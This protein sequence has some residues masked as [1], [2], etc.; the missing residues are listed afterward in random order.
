TMNAGVPK[1]NSEVA[2]STTAWLWSRLNPVSAARCSPTV[3]LP[4]PGRP[5]RKMIWVG[6]SAESRASVLFCFRCSCQ[7]TRLFLVE[8]DEYSARPTDPWLLH[9]IYCATDCN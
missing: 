6:M 4:T 7:A 5:Y 2:R 8:D 1:G 3:S 9:V